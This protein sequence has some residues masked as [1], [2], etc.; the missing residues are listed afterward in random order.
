MLCSF[1]IELKS[2]LN[3]GTLIGVGFTPMLSSF[4]IELKSDLKSSGGECVLKPT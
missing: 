1:R 3:D 2:D 4:R